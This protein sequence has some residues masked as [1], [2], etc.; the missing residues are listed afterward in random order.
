[1][2]HL[3]DIDIT[4]IINLL[5]WCNLVTIL[6]YVMY[7]LTAKDKSHF[8]ILKNFTISKVLVAASFFL[9]IFREV[10]PDFYTYYLANS[11]FYIGIHVELMV[12]TD[13]HSLRK[14]RT[15]NYQTAF[16]CAVILFY[17]TSLI[18]YRQANIRVAMSSLCIFAIFLMPSLRLLLNRTSDRFFKL[19]GLFYLTFALVLPPRAIHMLNHPESTL[20]TN[21]FIQSLSFLALF[22]VN[23]LS[24]SVLLL[25]I[26]E[27]A[28][29]V[30]IQLASTDFL[31]KLMNRYSF[32][33]NAEKIF[34]EHRQNGLDLTVLFMDLD[35]FKGVNDKYGHAVG[36]RVLVS[37][38]EVLRHSLRKS[39]IVCRYG[40]EEF[41][42][43]LPNTD[44]NAGLIVAKS[45][46]GRISQIKF[47]EIPD[48]TLTTSIGVFTGVP[49]EN[50]TLEDYLEAA[51]KMLYTAKENGRNR[52]EV[53]Q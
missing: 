5:F 9:M 35:K 10:L 47:D 34:T 26:K 40:G 48:L 42:V 7:W 18:V 1:M 8:N 28:D 3:F 19:L 32:L 36:D 21:S 11:L 29:K 38:A 51:D 33:T 53:A 20:F 43:L 37:F 24:S 13:V 44:P 50:E 52:I 31:T 15:V 41:V 16:L 39:D 14:K 45:I 27:N 25:V 30:N 22:L 23:I 49:L 17:I 2:E 12:I 46:H 4:T 6:I